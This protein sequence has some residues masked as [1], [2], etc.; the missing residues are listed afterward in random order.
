MYSC[1][2]ESQVSSQQNIDEKRNVNYS[3]SATFRI[4]C[5]RWDCGTRGEG[6]QAFE[7]K[8][9][10]VNGYKCFSRAALPNLGLDCVLHA[11]MPQI[12]TCTFTLYVLSVHSTDK[13]TS[14]LLFR[15]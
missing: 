10:K 6:G 1:T 9:S 7:F 3:Q 12:H 15:L 4:L 8:D 5:A 14:D 11:C 13:D 2:R